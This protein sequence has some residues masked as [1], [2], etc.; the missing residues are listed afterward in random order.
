V[1]TVKMDLELE[2]DLEAVA[3]TAGLTKSEFVRRELAG[4]VKRARQQRVPTPWELGEELF[5][6]VASATRGKGRLSQMRARDLIGKVRDAT[7]SR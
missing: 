3:R 5:G 4:A 1:L 6:K 2:R 7:A